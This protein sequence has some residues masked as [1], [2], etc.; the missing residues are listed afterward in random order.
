MVVIKISFVNWDPPKD[1]PVVIAG[2]Y[3]VSILL[4][5]PSSPWMT[6]WV[7]FFSFLAGDLFPSWGLLQS[8]FP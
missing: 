8:E 7:P 3:C 4:F 5:T 2:V 6:P 1:G